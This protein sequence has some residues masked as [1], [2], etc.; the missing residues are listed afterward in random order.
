MQLI[1]FTEIPN[2]ICKRHRSVFIN[3]E[4]VIKVMESNYPLH[5]IIIT[6]KK[7]IVVNEDYIKVVAKL[8]DSSPIIYYW[9][10]KP[11]E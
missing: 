4:Y 9:K 2:L 10:N 11:N 8:T 5:T 3:P 1:Q 6:T 7:T